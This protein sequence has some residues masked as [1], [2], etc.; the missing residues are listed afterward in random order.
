[1]SSLVVQSHIYTAFESL[2]FWYDLI[3][4]LHCLYLITTENFLTWTV[5]S[6]KVQILWLVRIVYSEK[7]DD[8]TLYCD[9]PVPIN[10][11]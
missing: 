4:M 5:V 7:F 8:L 1:M 3:G 11:Y 9:V 2:S 6:Y 10:V